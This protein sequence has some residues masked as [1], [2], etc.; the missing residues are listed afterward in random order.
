MHVYNVRWTFL[1]SRGQVD[2]GILSRYESSLTNDRQTHS[3]VINTQISG[4]Q[5]RILYDSCGKGL[6]YRYTGSGQF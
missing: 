5:S 2:N 3:F 1:Q 4:L 6:E